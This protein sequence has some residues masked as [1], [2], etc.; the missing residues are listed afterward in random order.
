MV[1]E[2]NI[3]DAEGIGA[4]VTEE[5]DTVI[6]CAAIVKHFADFNELKQVNVDGVENLI[7]LCLKKKARLI[8]L[9]TASISGEALEGMVTEKE[10]TENRLNIGQEVASNAYVHT[11]YLAEEKVLWAVAEHGLDAKIMRLGNLMSREEDGEFQI[12]FQTNN[13]MNSLRAYAALG[14]FPYSEMDEQV[15][16]SPIDETARFIINLAGT[17]SEFTV[18]HVY[19]SHMVDMGDVLAMMVSCG[20]HVKPVTDEVF[21][22]KLNRGLA[23]DRIN[24]LLSPLVN[25]DLID[26]AGRRDLPCDNRFTDQALYRLGLHWSITD[27]YYLK[28]MIEMLQSL[29]FFD[30][31][32]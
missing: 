8:H 18:F 31:S 21:T 12:N 24:T 29:G 25:Y 5:F 7:R 22:E 15:D 16:F 28:N 9:S 1:I 20:I 3:A 11:K 17:P 4:L 23:D 10:L 13:F 2:R 26:D 14:C 6:N 30:F 32:G 19:N 27:R